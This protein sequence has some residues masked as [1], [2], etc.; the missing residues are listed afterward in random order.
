MGMVRLALG[1]L[2]GLSLP[3]KGHAR[4]ANTLLRSLTAASVSSNRSLSELRVRYPHRGEGCQQGRKI[5]DAFID[6]T[7]P[8]VQKWTVGMSYMSDIDLGSWRERVWD[9][10]VLSIRRRP[11]CADPSSTAFAAVIVEMRPERAFP[12]VVK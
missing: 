2:L 9:A 10:H 3:S 11:N 5:L 1:V 8:V 4:M 12:W 6:L 7:M